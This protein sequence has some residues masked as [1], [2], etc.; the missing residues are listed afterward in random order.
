MRDNFILPKN[1]EIDASYTDYHELDSSN[2]L[3]FALNLTE[4]FL[5]S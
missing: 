5:I 1:A 3:K 2:F 4:S